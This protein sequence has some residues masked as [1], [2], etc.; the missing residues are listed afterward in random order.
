MIFS[1][2]SIVVA[3]R[4]GILICAISRICAG[5][6]MPTFSLCG[7]AAALLHARLPS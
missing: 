5:V 3:F 6:T 4:S 2:A 7:V 1:A